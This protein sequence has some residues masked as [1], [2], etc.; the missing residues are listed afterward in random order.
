MLE[1]SS[2]YDL[3]KQTLNYRIDDILATE[4]EDEPKTG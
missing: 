2:F 1:S 3:G 4:N